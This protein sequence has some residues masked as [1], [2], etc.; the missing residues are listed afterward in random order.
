MARRDYYVVLGVPRNASTDDIRK[1][2][3]QLAL[4]YHPDRNP[5][6]AEAERKFREVADAWNVLGDAESR[7]RFD[8]L[9]PMFTESGRPPSAE[10]MNDI[11]RDAFAGIFRRRKPDGPGEDLRYTVYFSAGFDF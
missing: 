2:F 11:L 5:G 4:K 8:K 1:A 10:E 3:R 9:G 6:D 7:S